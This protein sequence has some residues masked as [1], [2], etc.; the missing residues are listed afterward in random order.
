MMHKTLHSG[1]AVL[2]AF[3]ASV[4]SAGPSAETSPPRVNIPEP[5]EPP[6]LQSVVV[7][8]P[9]APPAPAPTYVGKT[10]SATPTGT[11]AAWVTASDYPKAAMR[12]GRSGIVGFRLNIGIDGRV[13]G[14][15][16]LTSSGSPDLDEA[17]CALVTRRA[18]FTPAKDGKGRPIAGTYSNRVRWILP[19]SPVVPKFEPFAG[20]QTFIVESDGTQTN[21]K[22]VVNGADVPAYSS[23]NPCTNGDVFAPYT[24]EEGK[25]VRRKV[26]ITASVSV[27][28]PDAVPPPTAPA[29][30]KPKKP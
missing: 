7:P 24:D 10:R 27:T 23:G 19:T 16:I 18:V 1:L 28:D 3:V 14:C 15:T 6:V 21:C 11:P 22:M 13:V 8:A 17:T 5:A 12:E 26:T 30:L 9:P 29:L 20:T 25:P 4:A 2:V